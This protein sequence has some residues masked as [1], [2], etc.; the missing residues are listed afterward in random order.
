M[1]ALIAAA[2][3]ILKNIS[4]ILNRETSADEKIKDESIKSTR[5]QKRAIVCARR[6]FDGNR[7]F[8]GIDAV[9]SRVLDDRQLKIYLNLREK[10]NKYS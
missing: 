5:N 3:Q 4:E 7:K 2:L 1:Q 8:E 6:I 9:A 10:F